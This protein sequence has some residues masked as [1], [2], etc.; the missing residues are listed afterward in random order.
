MELR[1]NTKLIK[2]FLLQYSKLAFITDF[3]VISFLELSI[4][5]VFWKTKFTF[6]YL[7]YFNTFLY[8]SVGCALLKI[9]LIK[10]SNLPN[11]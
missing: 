1:N 8:S 9:K 11:T 5:K 3:K 6:S 7:Y 4:L 10:K 2:T